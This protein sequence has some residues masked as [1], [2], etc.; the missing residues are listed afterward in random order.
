MSLRSPTDYESGGIFLLRGAIRS[1]IFEGAHEGHE[2]PTAGLENGRKFNSLF[3]SFA[4]FVT[5]VVIYTG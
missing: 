4:L 5:F 2:E 1:R 3:S